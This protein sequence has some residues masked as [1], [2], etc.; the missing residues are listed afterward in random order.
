MKEFIEIILKM[1]VYGSIAILLVILLRAL[2]RK[3]PKQTVLLFWIVAA[4]RLVCPLNFGTPISLFNLAPQ[5][6]I[7][8]LRPINVLSSATQ[9]PSETFNAYATGS[10]TADIYGAEDAV[11][12]YGSQTY[13]AH[14]DMFSYA[15]GE[16][17]NS[18][19]SSIAATD[20]P[21]NAGSSFAADDSSDLVTDSFATEGVTVSTVAFVVWFIGAA[22][23]VLSVAISVIRTN[24][25]LS[26]LFKRSGRYME[27]D[28]IHTPFVTG[29]INP[30]ICVPADIDISEKD[31]MLL[32]EHIH[33]K[34]H[35][36]LIKAFALVVLC[37]HWFNPLVWF[38][39]RLCMSDIEMRCDEAVID[40]LGDR[41][42]KNYCLSIVNHAAADDDF[43][44]FTT[45]FAKKSI[46][47]MEI[48]MRIKNLINY[49]KISRLTTV[50]VLI[51]ALSAS[52]VLTSCAQDIARD[53]TPD[54]QNTA[55]SFTHGQINYRL[56]AEDTFEYAPPKIA[57]DPNY[58]FFY[59]GAGIPS[60]D[61]DE[62]NSVAFVE[63]SDDDLMI[64]VKS[65][66]YPGDIEL[67]II[68]TKTKETKT[69]MV[70]GPVLTESLWPN[71]MGSCK[72]VT[73]TGTSE[74]I[75]GNEK[76]MS[77]ID[78]NGFPFGGYDGSKDIRID[79]SE[80]SVTPQ[81][82]RIGEETL[83][84]P[85]YKQPYS[86][87]D[88]IR[89]AEEENIPI[90]FGSRIVTTEIDLNDYP[91]CLSM[92]CAQGD[93][94]TYIV[95]NYDSDAVMDGVVLVNEENFTKY[96]DSNDSVLTIKT[97]SNHED[98][99]IIGMQSNYEPWE[100]YAPVSARFDSFEE[101]K[102]MYS[103]KAAKTVLAGGCDMNDPRIS[104]IPWERLE[105]DDP[106][107]LT[108]YIDK[109][110]YYILHRYFE[111]SK[112]QFYILYSVKDQ[113]LWYYEFI[114]RQLVTQGRIGVRFS[115]FDEFKSFYSAENMEKVL[116][117][118][119]EE[120][121]PRVEIVSWSHF[122]EPEENTVTD[123]IE[124]INS[125][126]LHRKS[127]DGKTLFSLTY[128]PATRSIVRLEYV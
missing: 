70:R 37:L 41:I 98:S 76:L 112:T 72:V 42:R 95:Y 106:S 33:V 83:V 107:I 26:R 2:F 46:G 65:F 87:Y 13:N 52:F 31:Y 92:A 6:V 119:Y 114:P 24:R 47:R 7:E 116:A 80:Q 32:H 44:V 57:A 28:A 8:D 40:I 110:D 5:S 66:D 15:G 11:Q 115:S 12:K 101:F 3:V 64:K 78:K 84:L 25:A 56:V 125:Y 14:K 126:I 89:R 23:I 43:R 30:K 77:D 22:V 111:D 117:G 59:K 27:S 16:T 79:P 62:P 18:F 20:S 123:Y 10:A 97:C 86:I 118:E 103:A 120:N 81:D 85:G 109:T 61:I 48:K 49:K 105:N 53:I 108:E 35:D 60:F 122:A 71:Y 91:N 38:A 45:A 73:S 58:R 36:A 55:L 82:V 74:Y 4:V 54:N 90:G 102:A 96:P 69:D 29:F 124:N 67:S 39:F 88:Q 50:I 75:L 34:N 127:A 63:N 68:N 17:D 94:V 121:D 19:S 99:V 51:I 113:R 100:V 128:F 1:S 9:D 104:S 93:Y 21:A